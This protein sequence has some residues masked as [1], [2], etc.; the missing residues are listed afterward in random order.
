[1]SDPIYCPCCG[2]PIVDDGR[3]RVDV[4]GGL[5]VAGGQVATL[6]KQEFDLFLALWQG[7]PRTFSKQQLMRATSGHGFDDREEKIVDVFVCKA[8]KKLKPLGLNIET[9]W[10]RGYRIV[11]PGRQAPEAAVQVRDMEGAQG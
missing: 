11:P 5:I 4:E 1:M 3:V 6:T 8:R 2:A 9:A 7:A 10:G